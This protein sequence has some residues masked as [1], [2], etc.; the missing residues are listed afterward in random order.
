MFKQ[1][2]FMSVAESGKTIVSVDVTW[3][4]RLL[5]IYGSATLNAWHQQS[6]VVQT[7]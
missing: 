2:C 1:I 4:E 5:Q 6:T 7:F 3:S